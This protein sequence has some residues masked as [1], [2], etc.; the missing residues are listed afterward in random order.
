MPDNTHEAILVAKTELR[1]GAASEIAADPGTPSRLWLG[2]LPSSGNTQPPELVGMLRQETYVRV[3][4]PI[5]P[6]QAAKNNNPKE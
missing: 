2:S 5:R 4:L 6:S 1:S 3:Y